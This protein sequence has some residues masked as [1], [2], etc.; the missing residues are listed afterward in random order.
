M[1]LA[2][3]VYSESLGFIFD[4]III[5]FIFLR[6]RHENLLSN[7]QLRKISFPF[8][9][10]HHAEKLIPI[11]P[12]G[13]VWVESLF[14]KVIEEFILIFF[15]FHIRLSDAVEELVLPVD[16]FIEKN[17]QIPHV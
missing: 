2:Q 1:N 15:S 13:G 7:K 16:E 14:N 11:A 4:F 6:L 3:N 8:N 10:Q 9:T 5:L 12:E 17:S